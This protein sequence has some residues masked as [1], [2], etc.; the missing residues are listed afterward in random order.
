MYSPQTVIIQLR[1]TPRSLRA[2]NASAA[3]RL[4]SI[5]W[6]I[7]LLWP[8]PSSVRFQSDLKV[9]LK[10]RCRDLPKRCTSAGSRLWSKVFLQLILLEL[11]IPAQE[12]IDNLP[13]NIP[14]VPM[15]RCLRK[16][17]QS[18]ITYLML[19]PRKWRL[20]SAEPWFPSSKTCTKLRITRKRPSSWPSASQTGTWWTLRSRRRNCLV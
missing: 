3:P 4:T 2:A 20:S 6:R 10:C 5:L 13:Q 14:K 19:R 16:N 17:L 7:C 8:I 11:Q 9:H 1:L 18:E 12:R 15:I